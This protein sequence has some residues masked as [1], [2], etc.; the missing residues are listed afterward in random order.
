MMQRRRNRG[1]YLITVIA[2]N[3]NQPLLI[4]RNLHLR[5][6]EIFKDDEIVDTEGYFDD[7]Y[8]EYLGE[9]LSINRLYEIIKDTLETDIEPEYLPE[10]QGD[11]KH[12]LANVEN[13]KNINYKVKSEDFEEKLAETINWFKTQLQ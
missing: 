8:K 6:K 1:R 3:I 4:E 7:E 2:V 13:M 11:I 10:R 12:S 5:F 9:K